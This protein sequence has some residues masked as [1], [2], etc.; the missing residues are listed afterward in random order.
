VGAS[1]SHYEFVQPAALRLTDI[2]W[3]ARLQAGSAPSRDVYAKAYVVD[4][5]ARAD[6][7]GAPTAKSAAR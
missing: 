7:S 1:L 6:A 5:P 4:K 2:G 3:R